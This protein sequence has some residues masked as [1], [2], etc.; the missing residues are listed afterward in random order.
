MS[1]YPFETAMK[2]TDSSPRSLFRSSDL[3]LYF[4]IYQSLLILYYICM[5][6]QVEVHACTQVCMCACVVCVCMCAYIYV[7]VCQIPMCAYVDDR[8]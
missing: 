7:F 1:Q 5:C 3:N 6:I 4:K 2:A 8:G